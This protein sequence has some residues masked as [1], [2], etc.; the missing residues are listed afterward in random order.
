VD[1]EP[2][3]QG[4]PLVQIQEAPAEMHQPIAVQAEVEA[5]AIHPPVLAAR[6]AM[7]RKTHKLTA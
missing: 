3:A 6:E 5:A 2:R 4:E 7:A 1:S